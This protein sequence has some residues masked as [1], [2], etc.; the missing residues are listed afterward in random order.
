MKVLVSESG[1]I[2]PDTPKYAA[3]AKLPGVRRGTRAL[4]GA[5]VVF[6]PDPPKKK[7]KRKDDG[8]NST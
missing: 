5:E 6:T 3:F 4:P 1:V 8:K 2:A 7:Y